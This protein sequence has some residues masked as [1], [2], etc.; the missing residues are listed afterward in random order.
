MA[1]V[2]SKVG[3]KDWAPAHLKDVEKLTKQI[4]SPNN[5]VRL[6]V[7]AAQAYQRVEDVKESDRVFSAAV[8]TAN[9][10]EAIDRR[11]EALLMIA[12]GQ[13]KLKKKSAAMA[14]FDEAVELARQVEKPELRA[15]LLIDVALKLR[16]AS[17]KSKVKKLLDEAE[18]IAKTIKAPDLQKEVNARINDERKR[19]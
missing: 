17:K 16:G 1:M 19:T 15:N 10:I 5:R 12:V 7:R 18:K 3:Q 9:G 14:T 6:L 8:E 11:S 2:Q 13:T 4:K